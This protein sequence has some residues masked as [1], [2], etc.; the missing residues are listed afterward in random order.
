[1]QN[2]KNLNQHEKK[3]EEHIRL[4]DNEDFAEEIEE[5]DE[6]TAGLPAL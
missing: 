1:M 2:K 4:F 5:D 6:D 3:S